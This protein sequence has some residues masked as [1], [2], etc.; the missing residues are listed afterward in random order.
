MTRR[1][2]LDAARI[3]FAENGFHGTSIDEVAARAGFTKGAVYSNFKSKDDLFLAVLDDHLEQQMGAIHAELEGGR[4]PE[5]E[6]PRMRDLIVE[7]MW[8]HDRD[9]DWGGALYFEYL[10]YARTNPE[11]AAKLA[12]GNRRT[13]EAV[14][15]LIEEEYGRLGIPPTI[16]TD[17][18]AKISLALFEGLNLLRLVDPSAVTDETLGQALEFMYAATYPAGDRDDPDR[19]GSG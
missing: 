19:R 18:M 14:E 2:L 6:I 17:A 12:E 4:P 15:R 1:H 8:G 10:L 16:P 5:E 13:R 3:V 7:R 9:D 11:A